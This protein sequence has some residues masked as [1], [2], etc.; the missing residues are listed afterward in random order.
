MRNDSKPDTA[1]IQP[2]MMMSSQIARTSDATTC[3]LKFSLKSI[4]CSGS[5]IARLYVS[6]TEQNDSIAPPFVENQLVI[7]TR[8]LLITKPNNGTAN[9]FFSVS[10]CAN[11]LLVRVKQWLNT[12][13]CRKYFMHS[14]INTVSHT[15][16]FEN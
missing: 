9:R 3:Q 5:F 11:R 8:Y 7:S 2:A 16:E 14:N 15:P 4:T 12:I 6:V 13:I 1:G 10:I